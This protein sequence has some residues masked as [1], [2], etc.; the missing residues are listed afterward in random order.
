MATTNDL[1]N[2]AVTDAA[3]NNIL[4]KKWYESKTL[5]INVLAAV[6]LAAQMK[7]GFI[8]GAD[9]QALALT[10]INAVLRNVT[11]DPI[12]W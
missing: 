12:V 5:W 1:V 8:F 7:Y 3:V 6:S 10:G 9:I 2:A 11:K 4:G